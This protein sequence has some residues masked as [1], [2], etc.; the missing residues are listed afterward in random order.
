MHADDV[1]G[2]RGTDG[3]EKYS[4]LDEAREWLIDALV[5]GRRPAK[6]LKDAARRDGI[7]LRTLERAKAELGVRS[8]H[9][10]FGVPWYWELPSQFTDVEDRQEKTL[11]SLAAF[12]KTAGNSRSTPT[13]P[14]DSLCGLF[15]TS[16]NGCDDV[17]KGWLP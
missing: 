6:E 15:G 10:G 9:G 4:A 8:G 13:P 3:G 12:E 1:I 5:D 17:E 14:S 2:D 7:C 11:A 16:R